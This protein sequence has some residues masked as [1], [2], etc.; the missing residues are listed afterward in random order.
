MS[1]TDKPL[2]R[3]LGAPRRVRSL[4][5]AAGAADG[6]SLTETVAAVHEQT[7][8]MVMA[9]C[10]TLD[11][12]IAAV[13]AGADLVG[14]TLAGYT[15]YTSK[16]PGPDLDLVAQLAT[17][18]DVPV[19]AEGRIHTPAQAAQALRAGAWAVVVG[20]AITHPTTITGWFAS[21]MADAR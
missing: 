5:M 6:R 3:Q 4:A 9:D 7:G 16:Q 13:A 17:A 19:I 18:I 14:T 10:S 8:A 20:T 2:R 15:S 12:G 21:A 11:E 1:T